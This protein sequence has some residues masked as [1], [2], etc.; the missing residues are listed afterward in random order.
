MEKLHKE[1]G[2]YTKDSSSFTL[3]LQKFHESRG[4][5]FRHAPR[6][7]GREVDLFALYNSVTAIGGWQKVNDLLKWDYIL[8]KLNF[9]KACAN[10]S[11]ALRQIYVR[12]LSVFEKVH[13][14]GEDA[15]EEADPGSE[16]RSGRKSNGAALVQVPMYYNRA[17]HD[18]P[19]SQRLVLGLAPCPGPSPEYSKL[20]MSLLSGLPNEEA[21]T[22]NVCTLLSNEGRHSLK[23]DRMPRLIDLLL[24]QAGLFPADDPTLRPMMLESWQ[25]VE[26][27][28]MERFWEDNL[29]A[30]TIALFNIGKG[31]KDEED[32][33]FNL[34]YEVGTRSIEGQRVLRIALIFHNLSFEER[35]AVILAKNRT[36][37]RFVML[38]A[39][40]RWSTLRQVALDTIG[41][42]A[43]KLVLYPAMEEDE[44]EV[45]SPDHCYEDL[46]GERQRWSCS[47]LRLTREGIQS[48]DRYLVVRCLDI[49]ARL[50]RQ[51]RNAEPL[52]AALDTPLCRRVF[53]LLTVHDLMLLIYALEALYMLSELGRDA[54]ERMLLVHRSMGILVS[55]LTLDPLVYG[56]LAQK[57]MKLIETVDPLLPPPQVPT[58]VNPAVPPTPLPMSA[59]LTPSMVATGS[60]AG[61]GMLGTP[62]APGAVSGVTG[63]TGPGP[64]VGPP[65]GGAAP[66]L[67]TTAAPQSDP[68]DTEAFAGTWVRAMYEPAPPGCSVARNDIYA[69]YV[70]FCSKAG[71]KSVI[72]ASTFASCVKA[73]YTQ[74]GIRRVDGANGVVSFH[75]DGLRKRLNPLPVPI[76][77]T[78]CLSISTQGNQASPPPS[79]ALATTAP[80]VMGTPPAPPPG[81]APGGSSNLIKSLLANKVSRNLQRQQQM[82]QQ[83]ATVVATSAD[84]EATPVTAG[85]PVLANSATPTRAPEPVRREVNPASAVS[86]HQPQ[87]HQQQPVVTTQSF[88]FISTTA[89]AAA[90]ASTITSV[91]PTAQTTQQAT[92][93]LTSA[94]QAKLQQQPQ[95]L[96]PNSV[97]PQTHVQSPGTTLHMRVQPHVQ[98]QVPTVHTQPQIQVQVQVPTSAAQTQHAQMQVQVPTSTVQPQQAQVHVQ[99]PTSAA[100]TPHAQIQVQVPTSVAHMLHAQVQAQASSSAIQAQQMQVQNS[101]VQAQQVQVQVP[102][103]AAQV[104]QGQIQVQVPGTTV[105]APPQVA[106]GANQLPPSS[107]PVQIQVPTVQA[108]Q[109]QI[110]VQ[111]P[112]AM[113]QTQPHIQVQVPTSA[114]QSQ[115][116]QVQ[117]PTSTLQQQQQVQVQVSS[118]ALQPQQVQV[119]VPNSALQPQQVQ[120]QVATT[121][122]V[123][124]QFQ[125]QMQVH[126]GPVVQT[127]VQPHQ[128]QVQV[129]TQICQAPLQTQVQTAAGPM[130]IQSAQPATMVQAP[131]QVVVSMAPTGQVPASI[132]VPAVSVQTSMSVQTPLQV[133]FSTPVS[134]PLLASAIASAQSSAP[135]SV[136]AV[137]L[138]QTLPTSLASN[139]TSNLAS[140]L[141]ANQTVVVGSS[142]LASNLSTGSNQTVVMAPNLASNLGGSSAVVVGSALPSNPV[143]AQGTSLAASLA[144]GGGLPPGATI[145]MVPNSATGITTGM[146]VV[147]PQGKL[148]AGAVGAT[149]LARSQAVANAINAGARGPLIVS[150]RPNGFQR[151]IV[152]EVSMPPECKQELPPSTQQAS[153]TSADHPVHNH[154]GENGAT[155][156]STTMTTT[157]T[158]TTAHKCVAIL[159]S[160]TSASGTAT[161]T[162]P[163]ESIVY[164]SSP[165]LN[166]LLDKGKMPLAME[167]ATLQNGS[168][169]DE[170]VQ[171]TDGS[172]AMV[173]SDDGGMA[174]TNGTGTVEKMTTSSDL[175]PIQDIVGSVESASKVISRTSVDAAVSS[176]LKRTAEPDGSGV[177]CAKRLRLE[178]SS[179]ATFQ[180]SDS[181]ERQASPPAAAVPAPQQQQQSAIVVA[182]TEATSG[183]QHVIVQQGVIQQSVMQHSTTQQQGG[184]LQHTCAHQAMVQKVPQQLQTA[185]SSATPQ[186]V[187][188]VATTSSAV[189]QPNLVKLLSTMDSSKTVTTVVA[190]NSTSATSVM[191]TVAAGSTPVSTQP[192]EVK[193]IVTASKTVTVDVE[194][195]STTPSVAGHH[196]LH[197]H[198]HHHKAAKLVYHCE[199]K[200]CDR[201]FSTPGA[202]FYHACKVHIPEADNDVHC[203]WDSCDD[204]KRRR[205]SLFTHLQDR[206]CNEQV[207]QIQAVRRQQISQFGKASLPPPAQP[208]PHPGYAPDAALLA[209]RRHALAYYNHRDASDEKESALAKSI[210]LTSALIIRNLATH[211]SRA[212]RYLR[213]YEQQLS[214]VAMSPL[215]SSRTIAQCLLEMSRVP[216]PD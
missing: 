160:T 143:M 175:S 176:A 167:S 109:R 122:A 209:I 180:V 14:L 93:C 169:E 70:T 39:L 157:T 138:A 9:P 141:A 108:Q 124:T 45:S 8:D 24:A 189:P 31:S 34:N 148:P 206:H 27:R 41:N 26:G 48:Q 36:F 186:M 57:G 30:E 95:A 163:V 182:R 120:M 96:V 123:Q 66:G 18:I 101:V 156:N 60:S 21:L 205:L 2:D 104:Q 173:I 210:R 137:S 20:C 183:A 188:A 164:K 49:M 92:T 119:Q 10:A 67:A 88:S 97:Q 61:P 195:K 85:T 52:L 71:R 80:P 63:T 174:V 79:P 114:I 115:Q 58:T 199:W 7:N 132:S 150:T 211:S 35:N 128:V 47:L 166:G 216:T 99:V 131:P 152:M 139:V 145:V 56:P 140:G 4:S 83:Q 129:P 105:Q 201:T 78:S 110:Q 1:P 107:A 38:S 168:A 51:E 94:L 29:D 37:I 81:G 213:R 44:D 103:S 134:T 190:T 89:A 194:K 192:M 184:V 17:Q 207:L 165:L 33:L 28:R 208:P 76:Q 162:K 15:D 32:E 147:R 136:S 171:H 72:S 198:H 149:L 125:Q 22:L 91:A 59:P 158:M 53:E 84:A 172:S 54:C 170:M 106:T 117:V 144:S 74:T 82:Q 130:L 177:G 19:E 179:E 11:L 181:T 153:V 3:E 202:V 62:S 5:P 204:M 151:D 16:S 133:T 127:Q 102:A 98:V 212:R 142:A 23:M 126:T 64:G 185:A 191:S 87:H 155:G 135:S 25:G 146:L 113:V 112:T 161:E 65:T 50:C 100:Q 6:I 111:V 118:A 42:L 12:Y 86:S 159:P 121:P 193:P 69:E 196:H 75:H 90:A 73:V 40:S 154:V 77:V 46:A 178:D 68:M 187:R 116:V 43:S 200:G 203:Q 197:H 13:F 214:T 215:E 55:L